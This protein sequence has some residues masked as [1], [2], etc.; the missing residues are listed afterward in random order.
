MGLAAGAAIGAVASIGSAVIGSSAAKSAANTQADAARYA[1]DMQH[2]QYEETRSDLAP[3]RTAGADALGSLTGKLSD[4]T[5][6]PTGFQQD[7]GY[8][9]ARSEGLRAVDSGAASHGGLMSGGTIK[10][11]M[12]FATGL[13]DQ[14]YGSWWARE[15][16]LKDATY[17]K[18]SGVATMGQN[19]ATQTGQMGQTAA[20]NAGNYVTQGANASAAGTIGSANAINGGLNNLASLATSGVF[21]GGGGSTYARLA[22]AVSQTFAQNPSIF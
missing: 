1:A 2:A 9:F 18:L 8:N 5:A 7:P 21:G 22:P 17:N 19:A 14:Q 4:L 11:E 6:R 12:R 15:M 10:D 20:A 16:A 3:W 13:A